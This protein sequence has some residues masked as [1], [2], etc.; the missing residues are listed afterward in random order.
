MR[1]V[2]V[3]YLGKFW[4]TVRNDDILARYSAILGDGLSQQTLRFHRELA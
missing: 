3:F 4:D 2:T 1:V